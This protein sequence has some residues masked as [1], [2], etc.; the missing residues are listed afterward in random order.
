MRGASCC[1]GSDARFVSD[2]DWRISGNLYQVRIGSKWF[3]IEDWQLLK[4]VPPNPTGRAI[5]W[6]SNP[7]FEGGFYIRCFTP[8]HES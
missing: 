8:S 4:P 3:D 1:N 6:H 5:I 7:E 2:D